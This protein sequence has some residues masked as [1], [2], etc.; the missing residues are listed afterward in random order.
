MINSLEA[1]IKPNL[2]TYFKTENLLKIYNIF[3]SDSEEDLR[4]NASE[5]ISIMISTG[6][7]RLHRAFISL[8][9][10]N[11]CIRYLKGKILK[12]SRNLFLCNLEVNFL[13]KI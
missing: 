7:E 13:F 4:R 3:T 9:G 10:V 12:N 6:D 11:Y 8:D 2:K 1:I 5:Q